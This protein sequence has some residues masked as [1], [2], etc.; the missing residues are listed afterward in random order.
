M[1]TTVC[2]G[3]AIF[4]LAGCETD[5]FA[6]PEAIDAMTKPLLQAAM[7]AQQGADYAKAAGHFR[8]LHQK[9]PDDRFVLLGLARNLRYVGAAKEA[10][11]TLERAWPSFAGDSKLMTELGKARL[12]NGNAKNAIVV[13]K[14]ALEIEPANWD[15]YSAMGIAYDLMELYVEASKWYLKALEMSPDNPVVLNNMAIS[16]AQSGDLDTAINTLKRASVLARRSPQV[17]QNLALF[18]GIRGDFKSAESLARMDLD[19][20]AVRNNLAF[21]Y[22]FGKENGGQRPKQAP[23]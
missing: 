4:L 5:E 1:R 15:T 11:R 17:R 14:A 21:Y 19:E 9:L 8:K 7:E 6:S 3:L 16:A 12:A 22:R 20:E 13:F 2:I 23:K 10:V 18:Y